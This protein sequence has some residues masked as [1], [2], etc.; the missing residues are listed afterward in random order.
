MNISAS[1]LSPDRVHIV[2]AKRIQGVVH[3]PG[4]KS[5]SH[6][7]AIIAALAHHGT[8][9]IT[10]FSTSEDCQST[11]HCLEQLGVKVNREAPSTVGIE[12]IGPRGFRYPSEPLNCGNSGS[13]MRMLAG[14]LAGHDVV[15]SLTGDESLRSR[16]M[17]RIIEPLNRMGA[18]IIGIMD[19]A[20]LTVLGHQPLT[21]I[22]YEMPI[23]SAQVNRPFYWQASMLKVAPKSS[24]LT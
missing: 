17:K 9:R 18:H 11:L 24:S 7:A 16:P 22:R 19:R 15:A 8:S 10:N 13:T 23:P 3:V 1:S 5:I 4:D 21:A 12:G 14:A 20:P 2:P 6:R